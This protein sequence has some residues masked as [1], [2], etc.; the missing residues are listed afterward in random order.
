MEIK[1]SWRD[2]E[3]GGQMQVTALADEGDASIYDFSFPDVPVTRER[4][5]TIR[6]D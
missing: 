3:T 4:P 5:I 6:R 2:Y 1:I